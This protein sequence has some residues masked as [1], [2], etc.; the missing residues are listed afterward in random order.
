MDMASKPLG[1]PFQVFASEKI[2]LFILITIIFSMVINTIKA[3]LWCGISRLFECFV[4]QMNAGVKDYLFHFLNSV[5]IR[6]WLHC[7]SDDCH[8]IIIITFFIHSF[9]LGTCYFVCY[10]HV[11]ETWYIY[12]PPQKGFKMDYLLP[13]NHFS[14]FLDHK[15]TDHTFH[16]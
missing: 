11:D 16:L 9:D 10:M 4:L 1:T 14:N 13:W 8:C 6:K 5:N 12:T 7:F 2:T 3:M 15:E